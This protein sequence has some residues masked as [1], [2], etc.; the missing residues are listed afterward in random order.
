V[1][2]IDRRDLLGA[3][4]AMGVAL[5][6]GI[7]ALAL[8]TAAFAASGAASGTASE[9]TLPIASP[10]SDDGVNSATSPAPSAQALLTAGTTT[11][12]W[13]WIR[14]ASMPAARRV[15]CNMDDVD[16]GWM[17]VAYSPRHAD[18]G[19]RYPNVWAG[20]EGVF[21]RMSVDTRQLWSDGVGATCSSVLKMASTLAERAPLLAQM[22]IANRVTY[23]NPQDLEINGSGDG[24]LTVSSS[25]ALTGTWTGVKGH[26][27]MSTATIRAPRDWVESANYWNV[28]SA[29]SE[30]SSTGRSASFVGTFSATQRNSS[31]LYGM[32]DVSPTTNSASSGVNSYAV[33][34][35]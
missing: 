2:D 21:D 33:L 31:F 14:T 13:Y 12:G 4:G 11:S 32:V 16:G 34:I 26:S 17:L 8:P 10:S 24:S 15:Y 3:G 20:G 9:T 22:Q 1:V 6:V 18:T 27:R 7:A 35:R 29:P 5:G 19:S 25:L 23:A 30:T 28:C